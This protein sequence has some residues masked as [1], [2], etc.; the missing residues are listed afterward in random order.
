M[1]NNAAERAAEAIFSGIAA[2]ARAGCASRGAEGGFGFRE[3][4]GP[5]GVQA[6]RQ[7]DAPD[8]CSGWGGGA[9]RSPVPHNAPPLY[10]ALSSGGKEEFMSEVQ[11]GRNVTRPWA[12]HR[13]SCRM[14]TTAQA[15]HAR[16]SATVRSVLHQGE[17]VRPRLYADVSRLPHGERSSGYSGARELLAQGGRR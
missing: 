6:A 12:R 15:A 7:R 9:G 4:M 16:P 2:A 8:V 1:A 10:H 5:R 13:G 11:H 17:L 14:I 3:A